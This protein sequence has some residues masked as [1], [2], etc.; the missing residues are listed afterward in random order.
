MYLPGTSD[1]IEQVVTSVSVDPNDPNKVVITLGNYGNDHYVYMSTNALDENPEFVSVQGDL[2]Q[3]PVYASLIEMDPNNDLVILGTEYGIYVTDNP[4]GG[5]TSWMQQNGTIGEVPVM[6][7]RQ[8]KIRKE[9]DE[10]PIVDPLG[11]IT[12]EIYPGNDNYGVIYAAT[13]G[14]GIIALDEFQKPVGIFEPAANQNK[15]ESL[16]IYPNPAINNAFV[17]VEL[18]ESTRLSINIYDLRGQVVRSIDKGIVNKGSYVFEVNSRDLAPG[19]YII[20][21]RNERD[22]RTAKF[23]VY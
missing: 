11:N 10:V 5:N 19:T 21:L 8:Q 4:N 15:E 3:A 6:M 9:D 13:Y 7:I 18:S 1:E 14:R 17:E 22:S 23:I 16:H 2:P 20:E 12:Y